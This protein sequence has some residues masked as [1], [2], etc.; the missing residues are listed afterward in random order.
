M[1]MS[2]CFALSIHE[3]P[4]VSLKYSHISLQFGLNACYSCFAEREEY[5]YV[6]KED[7]AAAAQKE[8]AEVGQC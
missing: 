2:C 4:R 6:S 3:V 7:K 5:K 1:G 8:A